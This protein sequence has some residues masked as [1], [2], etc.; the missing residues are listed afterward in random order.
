MRIE[1]KTTFLHDAERFTAGDVRTVPDELGEYFCRLGWATA[2][3][4]ATLVEPSPADTALSIDSA[5]HSQEVR[6]G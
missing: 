2:Q 3:D 6:H 1:C 5:K 4:G